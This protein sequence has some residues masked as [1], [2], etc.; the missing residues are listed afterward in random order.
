MLAILATCAIKLNRKY[1]SALTSR[2]I[3]YSHTEVCLYFPI[4]FRFGLLKIK[5]V[6]L[7][8]VMGMTAKGF[9]CCNTRG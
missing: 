8:L 4:D 2:M 6:F 5:N 1:L 3:P 9:H 7:R